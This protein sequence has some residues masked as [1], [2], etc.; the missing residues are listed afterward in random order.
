[1]R[2]LVAGWRAAETAPEN[3]QA[4]LL[5]TGVRKKDGSIVLAVFEPDLESDVGEPI[6]M[7]V[8]HPEEATRLLDRL[9]QGLDQAGQTKKVN[10]RL[11][12]RKHALA[13]R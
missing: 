6:G 10:R 12:V 1:M 9:M 13:K 3:A 5:Q 11:A 7:I 8:L 2:A 4:V